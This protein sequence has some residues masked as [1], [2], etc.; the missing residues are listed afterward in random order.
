MLRAK[1]QWPST[2]PEPQQKSPTSDQKP[3]DE[4]PL[5]SP[6][7][8]P[9]SASSLLSGTS[10]TPGSP[11]PG[12]AHSLV[13]PAGL[14]EV[15]AVRRGNSGEFREPRYWDV[16]PVQANRKPGSRTSKRIGG[17]SLLLGSLVLC[18]VAKV[19]EGKEGRHQDDRSHAYYC[20]QQNIIPGNLRRVQGRQRVHS[21]MQLSN[22]S[23]HKRFLIG[24]VLTW[25][26]SPVA[27]PPT[28]Y[29][30]AFLDS[31]GILR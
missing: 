6:K 4:S 30:A 18:P 17:A 3:R 16:V 14:S 15:T 28:G 19:Q 24:A 29:R 13:F 5:E 27:E 2:Q 20:D 26:G 1:E 25:A 8:S 11:T 21:F 23:R 10:K 9:G 7:R 22:L 31:A 12:P